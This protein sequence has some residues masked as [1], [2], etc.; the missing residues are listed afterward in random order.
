MFLKKILLSIAVLTV[1]SGCQMA[2]PEL[3]VGAKS[4]P[5]SV[6][7]SAS[8]LTISAPDGFCIDTKSIKETAQS[9]F[10]LMAGCNALRGKA[11]AQ[12]KSEL[13]TAVF[14]EPMEAAQNVTAETL[15]SYFATPQGKTA[16][17]RNGSPDSVVS[18]ASISDDGILVIHTK[19]SS[20]TTVDGLGSDDWRAFSVV[21]SRLMTLTAVQFS[22]MRSA[23]PAPDV[24]VLQAMRKLLQKNITS[25]D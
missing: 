18:E 23:G 19:D 2:L 22:G 12:P 5:K 25:S 20:P 24:L 4:A 21:Q 8:G 6:Q 17:S 15:A 16:L 14:S 10:V 1:V 9:G 7:L 3:G 13:L 11:T